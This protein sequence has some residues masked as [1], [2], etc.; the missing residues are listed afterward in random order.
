MKLRIRA[1]GLALGIV[2]GL[3]FFVA[4]LFSLWHGQGVTF[5]QIKPVL[6]LWVS[7]SIGGA[8]IGLVW[9]FV[10]GFIAGGLLAWLYNFF[11]KMLYRSAPTS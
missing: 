5:S 9:G 1:F 8:I 4:I 10:Y 11:H 3:G 2:V 7:R 6:G